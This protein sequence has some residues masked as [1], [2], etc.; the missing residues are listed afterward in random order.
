MFFPPTEIVQDD[1]FN[2][3]KQV[4]EF[5]HPILLAAKREYVSLGPKYKDDFINPVQEK[6]NQ[7]ENI[8]NS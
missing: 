1:D 4:A 7:I 2:V 5:M 6:L 3:D 8:L